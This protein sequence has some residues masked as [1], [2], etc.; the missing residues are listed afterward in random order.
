MDILDERDAVSRPRDNCGVCERIRQIEHGTNPYFVA[1]MSTGYVV[2]GD[3]QLFRGHSLL[4]CKHHVVELH[5]LNAETRRAFLEDMSI[6]AESVYH[7]FHPHKLNYELPGNG[8]PHLHW[9]IFPRHGDDPRPVGPVWVID[10]D[11]RYANER[12]PSDSERE[13]MKRALLGEL[14]THA[15]G[16]VRRTYLG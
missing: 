15:P 4:L 11:I 7:A 6:L 3:H 9:H 13:S 2:L 14:T 8:I 1:E 10:K 12:R 5:H 16:T